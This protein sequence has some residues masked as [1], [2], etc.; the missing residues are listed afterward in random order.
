VLNLAHRE[1]KNGAPVWHVLDFKTDRAVE[2]A[3]E[4]YEEQLRL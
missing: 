1:L 2:R 4:A 3:R